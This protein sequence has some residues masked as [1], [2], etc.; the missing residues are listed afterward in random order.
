MYRKLYSPFSD[1]YSFYDIKVIFTFC[2][3]SKENIYLGILYIYKVL[4]K[5]FLSLYT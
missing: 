3:Q 2:F 5:K 4:N 1:V